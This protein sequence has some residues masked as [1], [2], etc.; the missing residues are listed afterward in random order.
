MYHLGIGEVVSL[1]T[2]TRANQNRSCKIYEEL[3]MLLIN[4]A[5]QLC[6]KE[7]NLEIEFEGNIFALNATIID[8][9]LSTFYC[10]SF[11]KAK[12]E[13]KLHTHLDLKTSIPQV[14][15]FST[16][17]VHDVNLL[18]MISFE[19]NSFYIIDKR[20]CLINNATLLT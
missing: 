16:A 3:A 13:I 8:L 15:L 18:D 10:A 1:S 6:L 19:S 14:I 5:N 20:K 7:N 9:C 17:S 4:E 2:I 11:R 12:G